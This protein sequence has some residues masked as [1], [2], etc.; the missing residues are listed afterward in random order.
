MCVFRGFFSLLLLHGGGISWWATL[1]TTEHVLHARMR[2]CMHAGCNCP[3]AGPIACDECCLAAVA[4]AL[5]CPHPH[6]HPDP[7]APW[8]Y[9]ERMSIKQALMQFGPGRWQEV[10]ACLRGHPPAACMAAWPVRPV[11]WPLHACVGV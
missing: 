6:P 11:P 9:V 10:R 3:A 1:A 8:L 2:T 5:P 7:K 4:P